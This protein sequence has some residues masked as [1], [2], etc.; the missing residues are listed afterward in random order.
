M[1]PLHASA[2]SSHRSALGANLSDDEARPGALTAVSDQTRALADAGGSTVVEREANGVVLC[3]CID[4]ATVFCLGHRAESRVT[5]QDPGMR[6]AY[7]REP[8]E[9][10]QGLVARIASAALSGGAWPPARAHGQQQSAG[11]WATSWNV[12]PGGADGQTAR[13]AAPGHL[14]NAF[15]GKATYG[16]GWVGLALRGV[17]RGVPP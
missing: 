5:P 10:F 15:A 4:L 11:H 14:Q 2:I 17:A 7:R 13:R 3:A 6:M 16:P 8:R 1:C 12:H 9:A